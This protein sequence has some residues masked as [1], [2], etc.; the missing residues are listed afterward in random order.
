MTKRPV[1]ILSPLLLCILFF[2]N[3]PEIIAQDTS[4]RLSRIGESRVR[5]AEPGQMADSVYVWG[6]W[7]GQAKYHIPRGTTIPE[8][9]GYARGVESRRLTRQDD[10]QFDWSEQRLEVSVSRFNEEEGYEEFYEFTY[11]YDERLPEGFRDFTLKNRDVVTIQVRR[12][13]SFREYVTFV[14]TTLSAIATTYLA[15]ENIVNR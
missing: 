11:N 15:I 2:V 10:V 3:N 1:S 7:T 6:D 5:V 12:D 8:M 4:D 9:I 13:P 14:A